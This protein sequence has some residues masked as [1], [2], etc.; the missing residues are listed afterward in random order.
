MKIGIKLMVIITA[1]NLVGI[2]GLTLSSVVFAS[3]Q[4]T[5]IANEN[6]NNIAMNAA[7]QIQL[8]LEVP[9]DEI[10]AVAQIAGH[11][12]EF[13]ADER[14]PILNFML[15]TLAESNPN[16][17][18]VWAAFEPNALDGMDAAYVNTPGTDSTGRFLSSYSVS[19]GQ[20]TLEP[21]T[22]Y[23]IDD[24]YQVS[25]RSGKEGLLSLIII[26]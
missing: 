4:I 23:D 12:G 19:N 5:T 18:G 25:L 24:Y 1:V 2:G 16:Y 10:R 11:L 9:L 13:S 26:M 17:V 7:N 14:R 8:Y 15:E 20:I 21:L 22:D 6:M 3:N